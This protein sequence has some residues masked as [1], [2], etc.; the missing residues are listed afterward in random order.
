MKI[1]IQHIPTQGTTLA[2]SKEVKEFSVLKTV[3]EEGGC[4][5]LGP[6]TIELTV[7]PERDLFK[8]SGGIGADIQ[9][10]CSRCLVEFESR[11]AWRFTLRFSRAIPEELHADGEQEVELTADQIGLMFFKGDEIDFKDAVQE[12]VVLALPYKPL[13]S[14]ECKGLCPHCGT[15][16]NVESC[17]CTGGRSSSPFAV[18]QNHEWRSRNPEKK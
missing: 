1:Q 15:D 18:L 5:F 14:E 3:M 13:C 6:M 8:V 17:G 16:L 9:L 4:R 11:L 10:A 12:Q 7:V 2:Y